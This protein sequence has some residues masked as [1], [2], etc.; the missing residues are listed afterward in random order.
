MYWPWEDEIQ[1]SLWENYFY[2]G[3]VQYNGKMFSFTTEMK[4]IIIIYF[5][6]TNVM[7]NKI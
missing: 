1:N 2:M 4:K 7:S 6:D 5:C 3:E